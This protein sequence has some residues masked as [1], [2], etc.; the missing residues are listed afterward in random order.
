MFFPWKHSDRSNAALESSLRAMKKHQFI[1]LT[2]ATGFG[3]AFGVVADFVVG[4]VHVSLGDVALAVLLSPLVVTIGGRAVASSF[5]T[6]FLIGG[7]LF[8]PV[9][10]LLTWRWLVTR[11]MA[12][13]VMIAMWSAQGFFQVL[14]RLAMVMSA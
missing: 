5:S 2:V 1:T 3:V 13:A 9:W 7:L 6:V 10:A 4:G 12:F 14:H 11:R 8:W